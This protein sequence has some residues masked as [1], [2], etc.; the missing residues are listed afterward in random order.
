MVLRFNKGAAGMILLFWTFLL[1]FGCRASTEPMSIAQFVDDQTVQIDT[2]VFKEV[3]GIQ[4][5]LLI[6][7]PGSDFPQKRRP[8]RVWIHGGGWS[9]GN[10]GQFIPQIKYSAALGTVGI[11]IQYRLI[12]KEHNEIKPASSTI[13]DA[14]NDCADAIAYVRQHA[15]ELG[16]D[17]EKIVVI[18]DSAGGHLALCLGFLDFP[19]SSRAN[20][21][22]NCNGITDM[23]AEKW[24][25]NIAQ[26]NRDSIAASLSPI[27]HIDKDDA[28]VLNMNGDQDHVVEAIE[29]KGFHLA[30]L[31]SGID[32]EYILWKGA[33]HAFILTGYTAT[34]EQVN[35]ALWAIDAFLQ[36]RGFTAD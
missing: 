35:N 3:N 12:E 34:I 29:T 36:N 32:S 10:A 21:V 23:R 7:R 19:R 17:P 27:L 14:L 4:L 15:E 26:E 25:N 9:G 22:I 33:Q 18:G 6:A 8:A 24:I 30:C 11:S 31:D 16:I 13:W 1:M 2:V 20:V 5:C 28:P